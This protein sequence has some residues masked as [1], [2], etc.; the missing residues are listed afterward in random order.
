M[1]TDLETDTAV[2]V[3][4]KVQSSL[5]GIGC[6]SKE[7]IDISIL[8]LKDLLGFGFRLDLSEIEDIAI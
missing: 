1:D 7:N 5:H 6:E 4:H 8:Q 2:N 3:G